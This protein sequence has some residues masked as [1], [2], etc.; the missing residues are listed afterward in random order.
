MSFSF[1]LDVPVRYA[2]RYLCEVPLW[3]WLFV[4][5][6]PFDFFRHVC[7]HYDNFFSGGVWRFRCGPGCLLSLV[8][9]TEEWIFFGSHFVSLLEL[10]VLCVLLMAPSLFLVRVSVFAFIAFVSL[11]LSYSHHLIFFSGLVFGVSFVGVCLNSGFPASFAFTLVVFGSFD[12]PY[13]HFLLFF[14]GLVIRGSLVGHC[15]RSD[16]DIS[17]WSI[18]LIESGSVCSLV[19]YTLSRNCFW[20]GIPV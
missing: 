7:S 13:S 8:W 1:D 18:A 15:G 2:F 16:K 10:F 17:F 11:I 6:E 12:F 19:H 14:S 5:L 4:Y 3:T 9:R 20:L